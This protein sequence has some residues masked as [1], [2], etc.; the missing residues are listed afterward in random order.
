[1]GDQIMIHTYNPIKY[2]NYHTKKAKEILIGLSKKSKILF[3]LRKYFRT[4]LMLV[5]WLDH[6]TSKPNVHN[7]FVNN[8]D[9]LNKIFCMAHYSNHSKLDSYDANILKKAK[10]LGFH[11]ILYTNQDSILSE[12]VD[13]VILKPTKGRDAAV[14]ASFAKGLSQ[15]KVEETLDVCFMNNS[16][17]WDPEYF[18]E[19]YSRATSGSKNTIVFPTESCYPSL[20]VQPYSLFVSLD[21][22]GMVKFSRSFNWI[23]E[24]RF[25]RTNVMFYE[26]RL[27]KKLKTLGWEM[28][29]ICEAGS[30][31]TEYQNRI[32]TKVEFSE[33]QLLD[34]NPTT[35]L[36]GILP[37]M[38]LAGIKKAIALEVTRELSGRNELQRLLPN[39]Y[40][41]QSEKG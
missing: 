18:E 7:Y 32:N 21:K 25:K 19:I 29:S 14:L 38:G 33:Y 41:S 36:W 20:H 2:I 28:R 4:V 6:L 13:R 34:I 39:L 8:G 5:A 17:A 3:L 27:S 35:E 30:L 23:K 37:K 24:W 16:F 10:E 15:L 12:F 11:T 40:F 1:M 26:Y 22:L 9:N 31:A